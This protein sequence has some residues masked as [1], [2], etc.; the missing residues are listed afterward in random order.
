MD[1]RKAMRKRIFGWFSLVAV[2]ALTA[3]VQAE[4]TFTSAPRDNEEKEA[5]VFQP[6]VDLLTKATGQKVRFLHGDNY[7]VY[8]SEMRKGTYDIVFDG[9]HFVSWRMTKLQHVP[10]VKFP[11]NLVFVVAVKKDQ[12]KIGSLKDMGGRTMCAFPPP[13]LATLSVQFEF[14][15]PARQP[16]LLETDTF[17]QSYKNMVAGKCAGAILQKKLF[18]TLDKDAQAAKVIFTSKPYPNQAFSAGPK[19]T[20]EMRERIVKA[21]LSPEGAAATQKMRE[22]YKVQSLAPA[23]VEEFQGLGQLLRDVWGFGL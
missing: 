11:G 3:P 18:E 1:Y 5:Q 14:D 9:P 7:L 22:L 13:N 12:A 23:T 15:N 19:V 2:M 16:M 10:L 8:Q 21:L 20:P 17:P 6:L 4:L